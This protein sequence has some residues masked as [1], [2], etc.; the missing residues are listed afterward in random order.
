[1]KHNESSPIAAAKLAS[2]LP[3]HSA[4]RALRRSTL[5]VVATFWLAS[6][7]M[8]APIDTSIVAV[9]PLVKPA[10]GVDP[11]TP[12]ALPDVGPGQAQI[13]QFFK[14]PIVPG[15]P[16]PAAPGPASAAPPADG[17]DATL[18]AV[19]L[20][21]LPLPQF[22][23]TIYATI[24]KRNVSLDPAVQ[25]R[26]DLVSLRTG[27]PQT[28]AQLSAAAQTVLLA[29]GVS[30][31]EFEG[32][33][34]VVP[35]SG[36]GGASPEIIRGRAQP[37][38]PGSLRPIFYL[39]ELENTSFANVLSW[40][41]T[42]F[43][44]RVTAT[45][46]AARNAIMLSGQSDGVMAAV[47]AVRTLDRPSLRGHHSVRITPVFWSA[48]D[49][50]TRLV[51]VL[52]AQGY[53]ATQQPTAA[54]PIL[55]VPIAPVNSVIVFAVSEEA[56]NHTL[57]W[58]R[59]LDQTP[60]ARS[61]GRYVTYYVRNT[62][63][64]AV[65]K[66]LQD[67]LG[68]GTSTAPAPTPAAGAA[69]PKAAGSSR[70]VV[71]A[72]AN[73]IIIQSSPAEYQQIY[74]LLQELDRPARSALIMA[75]VAEVSLTDDEQFGFN[76]LLKQFS[77]GGYLVNGGMGPKPTG[78]VTSASGIALNIAKL[79]G[80]PR[81]LLT[82]LATSS[83]VRVLSNPSIVAINGQTASIQVGEDV[84]ILTSQISNA[85]TGTGS[86][87]G[88]MQTVQYR[89]VGIILKVKPVIHSGGRIDLE[90]SQEVSGVKEA[91]TGLGNSPVVTTRKVETRLSVVDGN[92]MLIGG[93]IREQRDGTNA[94]LPFLKDIP[95]AGALF[96]SS[97]T[98]KITRTELV[99]LITPHVL[100]DDFDSRAMTDAFR[101]QFGW[102]A[103]IPLSVKEQAVQAP[104]SPS[105]LLNDV[106]KP[107]EGSVPYLV[108]AP[109]AEALAA[110][111]RTRLQQSSGGGSLP[112]S[113]P[114]TPSAPANPAE[115]STSGSGPAAKS[116]TPTPGKEISDEA[117]RRELLDALR[118]AK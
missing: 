30:V 92:T 54:A 7:A 64:T 74:G 87:Q 31:N 37:D 17:S 111:P 106:P 52:T 56:L 11:A 16:R 19:S 90:I 104:L 38:V 108:P 26:T 83:R 51:E 107:T 95:V 10:R 21:G 5:A 3:A 86:G 43:Q 34:R 9:K 35:S 13:T 15:A 109:P 71:N 97:A 66:T 53:S 94:G 45:E 8:V 69:A 42:M 73:S 105:A 22:I 88:I 118:N 24:L 61:G 12:A 101:A 4:M 36:L 28:A 60:S 82:A 89:N 59:E 76:W 14:A 23:N 75:T 62:D 1:M 81:A 27:K 47:E 67:V 115:R 33:V 114:G 32:L 117:L 68:G 58:A 25:S 93:L 63:A 103:E 48:A 102:G 41:R 2:G 116:A 57:R 40:I 46:D 77:A 91:A 84:P 100:E 65:A 72:A 20:D 50:A 6:C 80:D 44:G 98:S 110:P 85:N 79:A 112:G 70:V 78:G 113:R 96:R 39:L 55:I 49:M 29:Y 99:L 18:S